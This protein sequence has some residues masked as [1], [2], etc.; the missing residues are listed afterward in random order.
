MKEMDGRKLSH[1]ALEEIRIRA[2]KRIEAGESPEVVIEALGFH[3]SVIYKWIGLYREGG[4]EALKGRK[5]AGPAPKL[6]GKHLRQ[7]YMIITANN[8]LHWALSL[9]CGRGR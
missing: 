7:L 3:R 8:P 2:V 4:I 5:A 1:E 6:N 9:R